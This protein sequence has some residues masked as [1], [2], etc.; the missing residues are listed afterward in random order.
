MDRVDREIVSGGGRHRFGDPLLVDAELRRALAAVGEAW[1]IAS[2]GAR[3]D[4]QADR[5]PGCA[6]TE[7]LDLADRVEVDVDRR[8]E[9]DVEIAFRDVRA[10]K[11][12]LLG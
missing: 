3:I 10:G 2:S 9:E 5:P 4:P 6:P 8:R 12:D 11:A 7:T 1:V